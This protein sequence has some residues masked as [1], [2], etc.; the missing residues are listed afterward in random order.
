[1][2]ALYLVCYDIADDRRLYRVHKTLVDFGRRLQYS[3]YEC[4]LSAADLARLQLLLADLIDHRADQVLFVRLGPET[5]ETAGRF[6]SL[7][8]PYTRSE[9]RSVVL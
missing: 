5:D 6:D 7:G 9:H 8:R 2:R 1:M 4:H 3:V